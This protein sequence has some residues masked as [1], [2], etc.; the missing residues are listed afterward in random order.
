MKAGIMSA[1]HPIPTPILLGPKL[2]PPLPIAPHPPYGQ[3]AVSLLGCTWDCSRP[4]EKTGGPGPTSMGYG[5]HGLSPQTQHPPLL[6]PPGHGPP[7][8]Q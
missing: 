4:N 5:K 1:P 6:N 2:S 3:E 8:R 7:G